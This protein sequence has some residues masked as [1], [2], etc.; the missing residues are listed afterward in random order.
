M[1]RKKFY[2]EMQS[3][4]DLISEESVPLIYEAINLFSPI[5]DELKMNSLDLL[6]EN[7]QGQQ[8]R[9]QVA[10]GI[11]QVIQEEKSIKY[12]DLIVQSAKLEDG[13]QEAQVLLCNTGDYDFGFLNEVERKLEDFL[14]QYEKHTRLYSI[15][16]CLSLS[17]SASE[18]SSSLRATQEF[19]SGFLSINFSYDLKSR[20][21][22]RSLDLYLSN[23]VSLRDYSEKL[24]ALSEIY[25]EII[26]L[27]GLTEN[28]HP[29]LI[30]HLENG[31]LWVKFAGHTLTATLLTSII[32]IAAKHYQEQFTVT[33]QLNNLPAAVKVADD[34]LRI[35][36]SLEKDGV[37]TAK[38][39]E[40]IESAT[41][42]ISKKLDVL[43]SDQPSVEINDH[44][45]DVG[46][47]AAERF[48]EE[49]R[50]KRL[51]HQDEQ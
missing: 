39:K 22:A 18:L 36:E 48:L 8:K 2:K 41:R 35:S 26:C 45:I 20:D 34:L 24:G 32:A 14:S 12:R 31:S 30:E 46:D 50:S 37:D 44:E 29:I 23:V 5:V 38:I 42:K 7:N 10:S 49:A 1:N 13:L 27:Y 16:T 28:D 6:T 15:S 51:G 4:N 47:V 21:D 17:I 19:L 9:K 40:N 11:K 33:G 25:N 43:L 3:L